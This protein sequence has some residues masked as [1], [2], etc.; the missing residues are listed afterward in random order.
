MMIFAVSMFACLDATA[1]YLGRSIAS[2]E[3]VWLR[4]AT[5]V[6]LLAIFLRVW[7]DFSPFRTR[8]PILQTVRGL[9]LL[10]ATFF[11]FWALQYLQLAETSAIT[12]AA[13]M[14][15][16]A[17]AGPV[18][19][20]QVGVRRWCAVIVGFIGVLVVLRPG[21]GAMHWA[22]G[23]SVLSM[24]CFASYTMMTRIMRR[25][26][27]AMGLL[28]LSALVGVVVLSPFSYGALTSLHGWQWVLAFLM[29]A[30]GASGHGALVIAHRI[31]S[32]S[33]L[34]PFIY[35]QMF[36]MITLGYVV[37]NDT[38][39]RWTVAG[40]L[41]IAASGLYIL[42]RERVRGQTVVNRTPPI[43]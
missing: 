17:L 6:L 32:A 1:K 3:V 33:L 22:A 4:Y 14:V 11:N 25:T 7:R 2:V 36:W 29:G 34:A 27:S 30:L 35:M 28:M 21:T 39:D 15:V 12:F 8:K 18:L 31:A 23:L 42:H 41:I 43:R 38:P 26:E 9:T 13:P 37:F 10:G 24:L 5:H 40:T 16:T 20:E 19:G